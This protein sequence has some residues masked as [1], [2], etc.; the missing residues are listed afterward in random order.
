MYS[1]FVRYVKVRAFRLEPLGGSAG[2]SSGGVPG[3][4]L[5]VDGEV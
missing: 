1:P 5:D 3:G 4:T 2:N